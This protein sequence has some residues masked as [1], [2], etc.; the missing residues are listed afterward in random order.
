MSSL[1]HISSGIAEYVFLLFAVLGLFILRQQPELR[2]PVPRTWTINPII[3]CVCSAFIVLRGV[4]TDPFQG[5]ALLVFN[6]GGLGLRRYIIGADQREHM[7]L[8][9]IPTR[10]DFE[11]NEYEFDFCSPLSH[12]FWIESDHNLRDSA[13][14]LVSHYWS[15]SIASS[16]LDHHNQVQLLHRTLCHTELS[17]TLRS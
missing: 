9:D 10:W 5:L 16:C 7:E 15:S 3:F 1:T 17:I 13:L 8:H 2:E 4:I 6:L 11:F 14:M 12:F